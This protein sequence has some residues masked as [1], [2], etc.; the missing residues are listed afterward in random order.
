MNWRE[1]VLVSVKNKSSG[2]K[3]E[4][5]FRQSLIPRIDTRRFVK[6]HFS[7]QETRAALR[8]DL[9]TESETLLH[10]VHRTRRRSRGWINPLMWTG[11]V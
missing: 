3:R 6:N 10:L 11:R 7:W 5:P 1:P 2:E 4:V 8:A 9:F